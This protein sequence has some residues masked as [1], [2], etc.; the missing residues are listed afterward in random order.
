MTIQLCVGTDHLPRFISD[1]ASLARSSE[2]HDDEGLSLVRQIA[3]VMFVDL[4]VEQVVRMCSVTRARLIRQRGSKS[5]GDDG[6][7]SGIRRNTHRRD[8]AFPGGSGTCARDI[9]SR[10]SPGVRVGE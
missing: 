3:S 4:T 1:A 10:T 5:A 7:D 6:H 2:G 8:H 9:A